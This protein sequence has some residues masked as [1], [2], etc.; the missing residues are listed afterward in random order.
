LALH[1][2]VA[3]MSC[4]SCSTRVERASLGVPGV[5]EATVNLATETL[6]VR[7]G[8]GFDALALERAVEQAGYA[9][10]THTLLLAVHD[11]TC[12]SCVGRVEQA[13]RG[14]PGVVEASVNLATETAQ[15]RVAG[16]AAAPDTDA[17]L[18]QAVRA[19]GYGAERDTAAALRPAA[20]RRLGEGWRV[21][22]AALL[23]APLLAPMLLWPLAGEGA[24]HAAMLP[25]WL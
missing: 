23:S 20:G 4:A 25:A 21:L 24:M 9:L 12:A 6:Q 8:P 5:V 19:A 17:A 14:V 3:G 16:A 18:L 10:P 11:M 1:F 15:V 2:P 13:L 22:A 7:P